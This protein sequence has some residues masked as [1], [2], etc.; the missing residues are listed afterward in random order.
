MPKLHHCS[1]TQWILI[2]STFIAIL[3]FMKFPCPLNVAQTTTVCKIHYK[4]QTEC[5]S[6]LVCATEWIYFYGFMSPWFL[7]SKHEYTMSFCFAVY[8]GCQ[9]SLLWADYSGIAN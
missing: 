3:H 2:L 9:C 7:L 5:L 8:L 6:Q 4:V 1:F